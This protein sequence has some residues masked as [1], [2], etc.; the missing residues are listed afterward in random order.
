M[1]FVRVLLIFALCALVKAQP[2]GCQNSNDP[3][4]IGNVNS[5]QT[6][7]DAAALKAFTVCYLTNVTAWTNPSFQPGYFGIQQ[8]YNCTADGTYYSIFVGQECVFNTLPNQVPSSCTANVIDPFTVISLWM[9]A[10]DA[11]EFDFRYNGLP[12]CRIG[13]AGQAQSAAFV[14]VNSAFAWISTSFSSDGNIQGFKT[15]QCPLSP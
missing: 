13:N 8:Q 4:N 5:Y 12:T 15:Y 14:R 9:G 3:I 10:T 7:D 1:L 11:V 2:T 6:C